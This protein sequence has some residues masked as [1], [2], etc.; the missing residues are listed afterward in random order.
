MTLPEERSDL[1][2]INSLLITSLAMIILGG[3]FMQIGQ[4]ASWDFTNWDSTNVN[5]FIGITGLIL[6]VAGPI[7]TIAR[8]NWLVKTAH[9]LATDRSILIGTD[10][11]YL[12]NASFA[13]G[14]VLGTIFIYIPIR[15]FVFGSFSPDILILLIPGTALSIYAVILSRTIWAAIRLQNAPVPSPKELITPKSDHPKPLPLK[16]QPAKAE[17]PIGATSE[18]PESGRVQDQKHGWLD[19]PIHPALPA[20][21]NE[22]V[23]FVLILIAAIVTRFYNLGTRVMSHDESLHTYFSYLLY[24]GQGYQH[25]PMMHGPLQFHLIALTYFLFGVSDF[26]ARVPAA[27]FSIAT[28][29]LVWYWRR[30]LGRPGA[31]IAGVLLVVSPYMLYYGRYVRN[32]SYVGFSGVLMLYVMLRYLETGAKKYIYLVSASLILHYVSKETSFIYAAQAL[33][34]LAVYFIARITRRKWEGHERAY[35][36]FIVALAIGVLL[37]GAALGLGLTGASKETLSAT[38]T[39]APANPTG[40]A[41]PFAPLEGGLSI[42]TILFAVAV[43]DFVVAVILLFIGYSWNRIR[44]ERSFDLL[45]VIG[46][47]VLPTLVAFLINFLK[48]WLNVAIPTDAISVSALTTRDLTIIGSISAA[49]FGISIVIGLLWNR[50]VWWKAALLFWGVFVVLYTTVFTNSAGFFTGLLGSLGY[51]LVQQGVERGSQPGYYYLLVQIPMY[52]FLPALG[53]ILAVIVAL[54]RKP[55]TAAI[56]SETGESSETMETLEGKV[57][58][59]E[60]LEPAEEKPESPEDFNFVNTFSLLLWWSV[61][62]VAALTYAG[63]K[64]PWLTVHIAWPMILLT[65]WALGYIVETTDW[66][67]LRTRKPW[68]VLALFFIFVT[69]LTVSLLAL[70]GPTP[71]F[72]GK[73]LASL[74]ATSD[75]LLPALASIASL[76]GL[77]YLLSN[78]SFR[79]VLRVLTLTIFGLLAVLTVRASFRASYVNYDDATEYLVYAH[80]ARGVKDVIEQAAEISQRTTGGMGVALAYDASAPDTGVSWPFVWYLRDFTNQRSFDVPTRS[81]RD[82]VIVIV[83]QKNFDKIGTALGPG[84]YRFDYIRMV[85]PN[86]D[87]FGLSFERDPDVPFPPD[88]KCRGILGFFKLFKSKDYTRVCNAI[89]DPNIRAGIWDIWFNRD[90]TRYGQAL[91]M[92]NPASNPARFTLAQWD[93]ADQ[94]R[95]YIRKDVAAQIWNYGVGPAEAVSEA[96]PYAANTVILPADQ[97]IDAASLQTTSL[98]A[99]RGLAFAPDGTFYVADSRNHRILHLDAV[100]S[101]LGAWGKASPGCPYPTANPPP[102][103]PLDTF[104]EPWGLAVGADGSVYVTDTWNDRVM[105]FTAEGKYIASWGHYGQAETP[106]AFWGPRGIAVDSQGR[107]YIADTGNKRIAI[108]DADGNYLNQFGSVGFEPGQ[109]D[110]PVGVAVAPDGVVYVTD[111]WNQRVQAFTS[112]VD[113]SVWMP[114]VQ[115]DVNAWF[116]QSLDNKPFIAVN[117]LGHVF[118]TDPEGYRVLEFDGQGKFVRAWGDY[119]AGPAEIG[120]ASGIAVDSEGHIWIT[121]AGNSRIMRFTLP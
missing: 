89:L 49:V 113:G 43:L 110:E 84:Y 64:M 44:A 77:T 58:I 105:K 96:D 90:Y 78:W 87:Y 60:S 53:A 18:T 74:Q 81:L 80:G 103:V 3:I 25:S 24:K 23:V 27:L 116:G 106:D 117:A 1:K 91:L 75:F 17:S 107:V 67:G 10:T 37:A 121:D 50:E 114:Y 86:Q 42:T 38:E 7:W 46:T 33:L 82:A 41:S 66:E 56:E 65:S 47:L 119:G 76:A 26:T 95:L 57:E 39:V 61:S 93:P 101:L 63:E 30:Y 20:I 6:M 32:E 40:A 5:A 70:L 111:T 29:W 9:A 16:T 102:N 72:R 99:P 104:C 115:W 51:W 62:I 109:F 118:V 48:P 4:S 2:K 13:I 94:M 79:Q 34:F 36:G 11:R 31:L 22:V 59:S 112:S 98:N 108:F 73:D 12:T 54:F 28:V 100:G 14:Y 68:I 35:Y 15:N 45:I 88:Y 69:S 97:I 92:E 8:Y 52:E 85:W 120:L 21:T 71:P 19:R 55:R 83:D